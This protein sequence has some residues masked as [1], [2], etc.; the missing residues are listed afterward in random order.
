M[1]RIAL[2]LLLLAAI[3]APAQT[4]RIQIAEIE[5]FG[6]KGVDLVKVKASSPIH[7]GEQFSLDRLSDVVSQIRSS[8]RESTGKDSTDVGPVCCDIQNNWMIYIGLHGQ[9][10]E[11]FH[12]NRIATSG[13]HFPSQVVLLYRETMDLLLPSIEAHATEDR[14]RGYAIST[15]PP[16]R[17]KQLAMREY[18]T[19]HADLIRRI[20]KNSSDSEQRTV[21]AQFLGYANHNN[22]QIL[23]L[24]NASF[25]SDEGVRNNA[26]RALGVLAESSPEIAKSIPA[27][28][29]V[30]MLNS[31]IW[32]DRNKASYLLGVL[33]RSRN[34]ALL[35]LLRRRALTSLIEM[36]RWREFG[37]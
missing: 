29:F 36:A 11:S 5:Y 1:I 24:V 12:Y 3:R 21:A 15:Y 34:P 8:I 31:G 23:S 35:S 32:K 9:N 16:L 19:H 6:T 33:S 37:H 13:I 30:S 28:K 22:L 26:V 18:A 20:L 7:E 4:Q 14:S 27:E 2:F 17:A 25:D 10:M